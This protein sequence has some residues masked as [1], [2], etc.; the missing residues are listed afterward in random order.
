MGLDIEHLNTSKTEQIPFRYGDE[1]FV[2]TRRHRKSDVNRVLI[3]VHPDCRIVASAPESASNKD[4]TDAL[5]KRSRWIYQ[6]VREF[7]KQSEYALPRQYISGES[8][9]YLGKRYV[10]KVDKDN[11]ETS[12]KLLRGKLQVNIRKGR[13][14]SVKE[15]LNDWY[16]LKAKEVFHQRLDQLI[17]QALWV[18]SKPNIRVLSMKTQWGS[19]SPN[20]LITLNPHLVKA[21]RQCIDYVIFHELCHIAEHNHSERFY[22]LLGQVMPGWEKVKD[23][24]DSMA[25]FYL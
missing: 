23:K 24:L 3:K 18:E 16:K 13:S 1:K 8:H 14:K 11:T 19:C 21:P 6:Q 17:D 22:R 4:V 9:F 2:A 5:K 15:L 12:V 25:N 10:L 20:G 7:R